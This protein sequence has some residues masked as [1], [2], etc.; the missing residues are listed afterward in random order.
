VKQDIGGAQDAREFFHPE[1]VSHHS[2]RH[3]QRGEDGEAWRRREAPFPHG[4]CAIQ[5]EQR[6][7]EEHE[8][9]GGI[10]THAARMPDIDVSDIAC[11]RGGGEKRI[12]P[13]INASEI[14]C[15]RQHSNEE[16][17]RGEDLGHPPT[18]RAGNAAPTGQ[19]QCGGGDADGGVEP[20]DHHPRQ[21]RKRGHGPVHPKQ[22]IAPRDEHRRDHRAAAHPG[23]GCFRFWQEGGWGCA[24]LGGRGERHFGEWEPTQ[25][26]PTRNKS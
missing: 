26:E 21:K 23:A 8:R 6:K 17:D 5:E 14:L 18:A 20:H 3:G 16:G 12:D 22:Q 9:K 10:Q 13:Q 11:D 7:P 1:Q 25:P 24:K 2:Q 19:R 4:D 15:G